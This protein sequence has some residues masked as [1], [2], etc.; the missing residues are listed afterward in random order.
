[1]EKGDERSETRLWK[2][3]TEDRRRETVRERR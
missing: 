2:R 1:M 3:E